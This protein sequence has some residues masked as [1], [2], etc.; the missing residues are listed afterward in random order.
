[1]SSLSFFFLPSLFLSLS[2]LRPT[3]GMGQSGGGGRRRELTQELA[4]VAVPGV[5]ESI[6]ARQHSAR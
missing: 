6:M 3:A 5:E 4:G 1:M 2:P